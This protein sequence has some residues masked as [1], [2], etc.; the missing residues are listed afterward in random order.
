MALIF[1][2]VAEAEWRAAESLGFFAGAAVDRRDGFIHLSTADQVR[3]TVVRHFSG[4]PDLL[5]VAVDEE[6]LS[7]RWE[8]SRGGE[9]FPHVYGP[10]SLDAVRWVRALPLGD[11]GV[12]QW[13]VGWDERG[14]GGE[15]PLG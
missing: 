3:E 5:I 6:A 13:P 7:L 12:H 2:I 11:D 9:L 4:Q 8:P 14:A 15:R 1:K 10:L